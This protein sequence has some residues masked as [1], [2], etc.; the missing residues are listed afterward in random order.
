MSMIQSMSPT[1]VVNGM[2]TRMNDDAGGTTTASPI[3][4]P[5]VGGSVG[6]TVKDRYC[7]YGDTWDWLF[8]KRKAEWKGRRYKQLHGKG[9]GWSFRNVHASDIESQLRMLL[10][11]PSSSP[12]SITK[13]SC[14]SSTSSSTCT[15]EEDAEAVHDHQEVESSSSSSSVRSSSSVHGT[16]VDTVEGEGMHHDEDCETKSAT[17]E[18]LASSSSSSSSSSVSTSSL[19]TSTH[20]TTSTQ[21]SSKY[22][23]NVSSHIV[24]HFKKYI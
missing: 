13:S 24:K 8:E 21:R 16:N 6:S 15:S 3:I 9:I 19:S 23:V 11:P 1:A 20:S 18:T 22:R 12:V 14:S 10:T 4:V 17:E 7:V 5:Q 2:M